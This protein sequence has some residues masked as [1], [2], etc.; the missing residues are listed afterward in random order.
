MV[1]IIGAIPR[2]MPV[3]THSELRLFPGQIC[4]SYISAYN[5]CVE[6]YVIRF[7]V[8]TYLIHLVASMT[9]LWEHKTTTHNRSFDMWRT[10]FTSDERGTRKQQ[11]NKTKKKKTFKLNKNN[12]HIQKK[13]RRMLVWSRLLRALVVNKSVKFSSFNRNTVICR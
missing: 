3:N 5:C 4:K 1:V 6:I 11:S 2:I 9:E 7:P 10:P 12:Y 13:S 8:R